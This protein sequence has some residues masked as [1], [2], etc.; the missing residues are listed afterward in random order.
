MF[1]AVVV[2]L[3]IGLTVSA[4]EII[5][6]RKIQKRE[7]FL[8]LSKASYLW[9]KVIIMFT[10]SAIQAILFVVVGNYVLEIQGMTFWYWLL[11]FSTFCFSNMLGLN[12][13]ASFNSAITI[14][15]LIPL[16]IIPQLLFSGVMV[17]FDKLNP[18]I[19]SQS[20][21]PV[22]GDMMTSRWAFEA[23]AV[24]QFKDNAFTKRTYK[25]D[26]AISVA[27][28]K[29][30]YWMPGIT[31]KLDN[32]EQNYK[33]PENK[34]EVEDALAMIKNE[35]EKE[36]KVRGN[37][38]ISQA[39][40]S[41]LNM[42]S[43]GPTVANQVREILNKL[44]N[45][46][47]ANFKNASAG[48]EKID[49]E[50]NKDSIS[51]ANYLREKD[52]YENESLQDLVTNRNTPYRILD[53]DGHYIQKI[54]PIYMDPVDSDFGRAQFFAPRKKFFG[55]FYDTYSVN[56]IVI[57]GMSLILAVTLY[58]ELLRKFI[59]MLENLFSRI[60]PKKSR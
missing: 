25:Y 5:R 44:K 36:L 58:F 42:S 10:L 8:N 60:G 3:F 1:M 40:L 2:A 20:V 4:E 41:G 32:A 56:I 9:S 57:W 55:N 53:L 15:I 7:S 11:L 38:K 17:K 26:K 23:L 21:V 47:L 49:G 16:L 34:K 46:Y 35:L 22:V 12:I 28:F 31:A 48:K 39:G 13:S 54:D 33:K 51:R 24:K 43:F 37:E 29:K 50:F 18:I 52:Q 14:Y 59:T 30:D 45:N 27:T 19:T 6:D